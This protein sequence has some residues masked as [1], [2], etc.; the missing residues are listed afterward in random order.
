MQSIEVVGESNLP[1]LTVAI[2]AGGESRRMGRSKATVPFGG[3]PL[4]CRLVERAYPVADELLITTNEPEN[5]GFLFDMPEAHK[6]RLECDLFDVRGSLTGFC[7]ALTKASHDYLAV[8]ACDMM[9]ISHEL[10]AAELRRAVEGGYDVVVPTNESGYEPF[11]AVYKRVPCL[12]AV[13][14]LLEAGEKSMKSVI[15]KTN[16]AI[17]EFAMDE[18]HAVVPYSGCFANCNT[19]EELAH[20]EARIF[21]GQEARA[22]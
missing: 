4:L 5:L 6:I 22:R 12:E 2:Q 17:C 16:L 1:K 19:P 18:V 21:G 14:A 13:R 15:M 10:F 9:N 8:C 20:A 11:H 3:R 7:T